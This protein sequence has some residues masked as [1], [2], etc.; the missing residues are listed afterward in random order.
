M[1]GT[2]VP[3]SFN[4]SK[5][6]DSGEWKRLRETAGGMGEGAAI[7]TLK[8]TTKHILTMDVN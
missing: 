8:R 1:K 7:D 3:K 5:E 2:P 4:E 6:S